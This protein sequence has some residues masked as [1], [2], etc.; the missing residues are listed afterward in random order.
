MKKIFSLLLFLLAS[1]TVLAQ[2]KEVTPSRNIHIVN[3]LGRGL[4]MESSIHY[5]DEGPLSLNMFS[6]RKD[7]YPM[8]LNLEY[9]IHWDIERFKIGNTT[10]SAPT[11]RTLMNPFSSWIHPDYK[12][13]NTLLYLQTCFDY[14]ELCRR[15]A[16]WDLKKGSSFD[17]RSVTGF[18]LDVA[19]SFLAE[20]KEATSQGQDEEEVKNYSEAIRQELEKTPE[21]R[22]DDLV[23][24]PK[25]F[26][27]G[28]HVGIGS[29]IYTGILPQY[30][31]PMTG[32]LFGFDLVYNRFNIFMG[33][34]LGWGGRLKRDIVLDGYQWNAGEKMKGGN[35]ELSVGYSVYNTQWWRLTPFA[36]IGVGF[37][38]YPINYVNPDK[39][40]DEISGFRYQAGIN[41]D[42]KIHRL[43]EYTDR[44]TTY[45][46]TETMVRARIYAAHNNFAYPAPAWSINFG[47]CIN[48]LGVILKH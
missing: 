47:L 26:G 17:L 22:F 14:V 42:F 45:G 36:G 27:C 19:D 18:H 11:T 41:A 40:S 7:K 9:G 38:D 29:E 43:I 10:I 15:R 3:D 4:E 46:V 20:M 13:D 21:A 39:D 34:L 32:L 30:V 1:I 8:I 25:G 5:W 33:G 28:M 2:D 23:I 12:N 24:D 31:T 48:V 16:Q 6:V 44:G 35:M 37:I